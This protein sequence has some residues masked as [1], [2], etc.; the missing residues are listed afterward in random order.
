MLMFLRMTGHG[1]AEL[2]VKLEEIER[3]L[4]LALAHVRAIS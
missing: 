4:V 1:D 2:G 3:G